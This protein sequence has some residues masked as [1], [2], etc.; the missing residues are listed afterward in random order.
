LSL[1]ERFPTRYY[2]PKVVNGVYMSRSNVELNREFNSPNVIG[3]MQ[4]IRLRYAGH[5]IRVTED[6]PQ[7]ALFRAVPEGRR[8]Q[9]RPKFR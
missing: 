7:R 4:S 8:N 1:R 5:M 2:G 6:L 9:R 3:V